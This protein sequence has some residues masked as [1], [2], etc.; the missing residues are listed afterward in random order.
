MEIHPALFVCPSRA[1]AIASIAVSTRW[2]DKAGL[3][4]LSVKT[5]VVKLNKTITPSTVGVQRLIYGGL[6]LPQ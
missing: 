4:H 5:D 3:L 1:S 6:W 2:M